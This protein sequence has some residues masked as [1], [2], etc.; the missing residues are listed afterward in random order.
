[1]VVWQAI[2]Q[3]INRRRYGRR[4][5]GAAGVIHL[6]DGG[7]EIL[8]TLQDRSVGGACLHL[9]DPFILPSFFVL[10][11]PAEQIERQCTLV[12][13]DKERAGVRFR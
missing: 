6:L 4:V 8:C 2:K 3:A 9:E 11:V 1:M 12:W 13:R 10:I 5:S 7:K